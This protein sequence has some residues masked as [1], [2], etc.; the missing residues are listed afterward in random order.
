MTAA[1]VGYGIVG[2]ATHLSLYQNSEDVVTVDADTVRDF[3]AA[4]HDIIYIC[5]PTSTH[6]DLL[7]LTALVRRFR[8]EAPNAVVCIR[9]SV[10][11]GYISHDLADVN[12]HIVYLPEFLRERR[13]QQDC[14]N[15]A[16]VIG[17]NHGLHNK[18]PIQDDRPRYTT[19]IAEAE[20]LKMMVNSYAALRVVFANHVHDLAQAYGAQYTSVEKIYDAIQLRDQNYLQV[21]PE[22]RGFGGKCLPK[23]LDFLIGSFARAG[24]PQ[25]LFDSVRDDNARWPT[26]VRKN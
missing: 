12:D 6:D 11:V 1:I 23:D 2:R 25:T 15:N 20:V 21:N 4:K 10:P 18:I 24:L 14:Q 13:W 5:V 17:S 7:E 16:W 9:S 19:G 22:L 8:S 3:D 26:T